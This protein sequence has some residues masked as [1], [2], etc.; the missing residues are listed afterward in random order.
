ME[1]LEPWEEIVGRLSEVDERR[2]ETRVVIGDEE[3]E[4]PSDI[5]LPS[6]SGTTVGI[7]RTNKTF[8][9]EVMEDD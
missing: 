5:E 8:L 6:E 4:L 1:H 3:I 9:V 2:F 7:L